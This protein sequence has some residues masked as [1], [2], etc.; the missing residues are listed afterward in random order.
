MMLGVHYSASIHSVSAHR[1][2]YEG[3]T[4]CRTRL[5][6]PRGDRV[7]GRRGKKGD[8]T[9]GAPRGAAYGT[10]ANRRVVGR[11][12]DAQA[13]RLSNTTSV[14]AS[15]GTSSSVH[16]HPGV[17]AVSPHSPPPCAPSVLPSL[18]S[19]SSTPS[20][21]APPSP[22]P[23][24]APPPSSSLSSPPPPPPPP[25]TWQRSWPPCAGRQSALQYT[26]HDQRRCAVWSLAPSLSTCGT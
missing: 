26:M 20:A 21:A 24:A 3:R 22:P 18:P 4:S 9:T 25:R 13:H 19:A 10:V 8:T 2:A 5:R 23:P 15:G 1:E 7:R 12:F 11:R 16:S 17:P 14:P 6:G